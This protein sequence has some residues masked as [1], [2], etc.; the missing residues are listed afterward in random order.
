MKRFITFTG[1]ILSALAFIFLTFSAI[2]ADVIENLPF[3]TVTANNTF[4]YTG[5]IIS[6]ILFIVC[7]FLFR[8]AKET[9]EFNEFGVR[10]RGAKRKLSSYRRE[11]VEALQFAEIESILPSSELKKMTHKGSV[12]PDEDLNRLIG[13]QNVKDKI[14]EMRARMEFD[15]HSGKSDSSKEM[16]HMVFYGSPGTGKTTVAR[17]MAGILYEYGYIDRNMVVEID[18]NF[19]KGRTAADTEKKVRIIISAIKGGVL[20]IDEA[21]AMT[22]SG[23]SA[24]KQAIATLIKE[25][26]DKK[27]SLVVIFAGYTAEMN[28]MLEIN[29]GFRSRIKDYIEFP[30]YSDEELCRIASLIAA[31]KGFTIMPSALKKL[32]ERFQNEKRQKTWGNGRTVRNVIEE[33]IDTHALNFEKKILPKNSRNTLGAIDINVIPKKHI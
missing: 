25:M 13:M 7:G 31:E 14:M 9:E 8:I 20:F 6:F 23:D 28:Q 22:Q 5:L 11:Q 33:S 26:E 1:M 18:G 4:L 16:H 24:G 30:D 19:L 12:D 32:S 21:Y 17:I 2:A 15:L 27:D 10:K 3:S 29:P